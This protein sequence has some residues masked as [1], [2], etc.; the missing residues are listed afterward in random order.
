MP[1]VQVF[2]CWG[3]PPVDSK[4]VSIPSL[5]LAASG[6]SEPRHRP[7]PGYR[8]GIADTAVDC[9]IVGISTSIL[10][11]IAPFDEFSLPFFSP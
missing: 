10:S 1:T 8:D 4:S 11:S 3:V 2:K 5:A 9:C 6:S 7:G